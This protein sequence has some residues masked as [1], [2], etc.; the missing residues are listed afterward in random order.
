MP[1]SSSLQCQGNGIVLHKDSARW[2]YSFPPSLAVFSSP[3][4]II[5]LNSGSPFREEGIPMKRLLTPFHGK[6]ISI[7]VLA[8]V[9]ANFTIASA[10][11]AMFVPSAPQA[12][13]TRLYDR[14]ADLAK[15]QRALESKTLQQL[16][17][18]YGLSPGMALDKINRLSDEQ[19]HQFATHIDALQAGGM[20]NSDLIIILLLIL[21]I[22]III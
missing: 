15:I 18:N 19:V 22:L 14:T 12:Q 11:E 20:R 21:L 3:R 6:R 1:R 7:Y 16:L 8:V 17:M 5:E 2:H 13:S 10:A 4:V 9:I